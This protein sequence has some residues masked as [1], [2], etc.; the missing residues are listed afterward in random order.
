M[1]L[2]Q[3]IDNYIM[4]DMFNDYHSIETIQVC[5]L[6]DGGFFDNTDKSW[7]W[8]KYSDE[9]DARLRKKILD[10]YWFRE[11]SM[12][13]PGRWK[14]K[15]ISRM[16]ELMPTYIMMYTLMDKAK[17]NLLATA[18]TYETEKYNQIYAK[19]DDNNYKGRTI[20]STFPETLVGG[21]SDYLSDGTDS[22][23]ENILKENVNNDHNKANDITK[24][25]DW[26]DRILQLDTEIGNVDLM[27]IEKLDPMFSCLYTS[28]INGI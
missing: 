1:E 21:N 3:K 26:F 14:H 4:P 17:T 24:S 18:N 10:H 16:N 20:S 23:N 15:F 2:P 13:P 12:T 7:D 6:Y 25:K 11:I 5:E 8:E 27:I 22:Q 9:Q 19:N 28:Y